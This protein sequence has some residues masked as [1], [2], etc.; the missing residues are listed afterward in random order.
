[1]PLA[2][3]KIKWGVGEVEEEGYVEKSLLQDLSKRYENLLVD[4][5]AFRDAVE[6]ACGN[7]LKMSTTLLKHKLKKLKEWQLIRLRNSIANR[8]VVEFENLDDFL[9]ENPQMKAMQQ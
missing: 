4:E 5:Q 1:M 2:Y 3:S 6:L 9:I 8:R 7:P